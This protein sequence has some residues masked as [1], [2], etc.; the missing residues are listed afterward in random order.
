MDNDTVK[1]LF[2][3]PNK[4]SLVNHPTHYQWQ[5]FEV[6]DIIDDFKLNFNLGNAVKYLLRADKKG[7]KVT[8]LQK[9]IWYI[10][11][12]LDDER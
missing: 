7:N 8:D 10:E 12:E 6:I 4:E 1:D 2:G 9:A 11:R 5:I 3:T